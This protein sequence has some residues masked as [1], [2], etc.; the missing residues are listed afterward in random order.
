MIGL[1]SN[2]VIKQ[3]ERGCH[4][5]TKLYTIENLLV[6]K[7]YRSRNRHFEGVIT[8]AEKREGIWYGENTE[9]YVVQIDVPKYLSDRYATVAVKIGE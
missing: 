6:G 5:A 1:Q 9:A 2:K 7:T 8:H 3:K 4:M